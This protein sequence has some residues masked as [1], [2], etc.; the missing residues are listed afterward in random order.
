MKRIVLAGVA[1]CCSCFAQARVDLEYHAAPP[2]DSKVP[3]EY[4][5]KR[6]ALRHQVWN[7]DHLT[8]A[9]EQALAREQQREAVESAKRQQRHL[10]QQQRKQHCLRIHSKDPHREVK[11]YIPNF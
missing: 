3:E 10:A 11:C 8:Q 2:K 6:G 9:N 5:K 4:Q 1:L 7:V